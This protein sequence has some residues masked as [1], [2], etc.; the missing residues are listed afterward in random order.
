MNE[1]DIP[2]EAESPTDA[3]T[4]AEGRTTYCHI[5]FRAGIR[6]ITARTSLVH[7]R[8]GEL[9]MVQTEQGLEPALTGSLI[10]TLPRQ[11]T[12]SAAC[13]VIVRRA[14]AEER[15]QYE[16]LLMQ[17]QEAFVF[18]RDQAEQ[19]ALEMSLVRVERF[20]D[21][22]KM[23]F[24]FTADNRVDFRELVKILVRQYRTRIEMRQIGVRHETQMLGGLGLCGREL[25]CSSFL[26]VFDSVSI[27]MAKV[28]DLPLN[29]AKISGNCNRLL[30]CLTYEY[31]HY[32]SAR[33]QMPKPGKTLNL[34]GRTCQVLHQHPL[35]GSLIVSFPDGG[36]REVSEAEWQK[37]EKTPAPGTAESAQTDSA[38]ES[39]PRPAGKTHE[40][41]TAEQSATPKPRHGRRKKSGKTPQE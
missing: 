21:G 40:K 6:E 5:R 36:R 2:E 15:W 12:D 14:T 29:P 26:N 10:Y 18:C 24:Y 23:I 4:A 37:A 34:G 20:F 35:T 39:A 8:P 32:K 16:H 27:K 19:L 31:E 17:E 25:C 3:E 30:C 38:S 22:S 41:K 33:K 13:P 28:Q 9:V 1:S 11:D 7:L